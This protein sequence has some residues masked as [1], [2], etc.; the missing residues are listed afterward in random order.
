MQNIF[1]LF[2]FSKNRPT[3]QWSGAK[4][5]AEWLRVHVL[6]PEHGCLEKKKKALI[7]DRFELNLRYSTSRC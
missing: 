4:H 2:R 1:V 3:L 7:N 6:S 5:A